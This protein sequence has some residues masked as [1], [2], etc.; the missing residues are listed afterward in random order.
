MK[1]KCYS[2][3][4][5]SFSW[6]ISKK[7]TLRAGLNGEFKFFSITP[8]DNMHILSF[9]RESKEGS[10]QM[11]KARN[12]ASGRAFTCNDMVKILK[13]DAGASQTIYGL[14]PCD[15]DTG[16]IDFYLEPGSKVEQLRV[17]QVAPQL[18][19]QLLVGRVTQR[20][21]KERLIS[22]ITEAKDNSIELLNMLES[23]DQTKQTRVM[24]GVYRA[25][26][27]EA[28]YLIG[29]LSEEAQHG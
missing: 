23:E 1:I 15:R 10:R 12:E 14:E 2:Q 19:P 25:E 7:E 16:T 28:E 22:F 11:H 20:L 29:I 26:I 24:A 3:N 6:Y 9:S 4:G 5:K 17:E 8:D 18:D 21:D 13:P 27:E